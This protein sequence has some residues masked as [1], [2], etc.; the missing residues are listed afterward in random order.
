MDPAPIA[1]GRTARR[2]RCEVEPGFALFCELAS[3]LLTGFGLAVELLR[4][5]GG[6][7]GIAQAQNFNF[8]VAPFGFD[9]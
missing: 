4:D 1:F 3:G 7:A 8:E 6:A 2:R 5:R 9:R